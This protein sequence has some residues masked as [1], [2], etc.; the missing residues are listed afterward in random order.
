MAVD[1]SRLGVKIHFTFVAY[2]YRLRF[3]MWSLLVMPI[4][5][6]VDLAKNYDDDD[7][8]GGYSGNLRFID[9]KS[10]FSLKTNRCD[11]VSENMKY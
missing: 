6:E 3:P 7:D 8:G 9:F 11:R 2:M 5:A 4:T 10:H 1:A